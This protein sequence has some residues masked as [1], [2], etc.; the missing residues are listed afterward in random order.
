MYLIHRQL[1]VVEMLLAENCQ[2]FVWLEMMIEGIVKSPHRQHLC[3]IVKL[4]MIA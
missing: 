3:V 4:T 2:V 1:N